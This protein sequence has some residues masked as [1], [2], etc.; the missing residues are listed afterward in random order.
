MMSRTAG[1]PSRVL[2]TRCMYGMSVVADRPR[3]LAAKP[4]PDPTVLAEAA[5]TAADD[6]RHPVRRLHD[7]LP[8]HDRESS[9]LPL[10]YVSELAQSLRLRHGRTLWNR[11]VRQKSCKCGTANRPATCLVPPHETRAF[12]VWGVSPSR[13]ST[14]PQSRSPA[15][16]STASGPPHRSRGNAVRCRGR[17]P[18]QSTPTGAVLGLGTA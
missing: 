8:H 5:K 11:R 12:R 2:A 18:Q 14:P 10:P 6:V 17:C 13:D 9:E 15:P 3:Q 1:S 4:Q 7:S 16:R